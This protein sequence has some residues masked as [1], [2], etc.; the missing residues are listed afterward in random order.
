MCPFCIR[1][2]VGK[3]HTDCTSDLEDST[4]GCIPEGVA[5]E[6]ECVSIG[7]LSFVDEKVDGTCLGLESLFG[8]AGN[9]GV[10]DL[11]FARGADKG[12]VLYIKKDIACAL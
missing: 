8:Y 12:F 7:N 4:G 6:V 5:V 3:P 1:V 11:V 9:Y 2:D 10:D